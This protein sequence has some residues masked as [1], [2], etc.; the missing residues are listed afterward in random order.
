VRDDLLQ[1]RQPEF[2]MSVRRCGPTEYTW[3]VG[4]ALVRVT[5]EIP[6]SKAHKIRDAVGAEGDG[7]SPR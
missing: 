4:R 6:P 7:G 2:H 1:E 3:I 5:G